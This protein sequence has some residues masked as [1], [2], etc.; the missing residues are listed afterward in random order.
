MNIYIYLVK[1]HN[2]DVNIGVVIFYYYNITC[3]DFYY[4]FL[5]IYIYKY[6]TCL[7]CFQNAE[8]IEFE[9]RK[10]LPRLSRCQIAFCYIFRIG[11]YI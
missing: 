6:M 1:N 3:V 11:F 10:T 4:I 7:H 9:N 2:A 8:K 5:D